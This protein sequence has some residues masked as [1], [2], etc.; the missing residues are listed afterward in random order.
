MEVDPHV[1]I[2]VSR[3]EQFYVMFYH[4]PMEKERF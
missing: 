1:I 3:R 4:A 2:N